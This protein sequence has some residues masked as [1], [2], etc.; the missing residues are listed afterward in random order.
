MFRGS[1]GMLLPFLVVAVLSAAIGQESLP[2]G[3]PKVAAV[4]RVF[5]QIVRAVG[6]GRPAPGIRVMPLGWQGRNRIAWFDPASRTITLEERTYDLC[7]SLGRDSLDA[8]AVLLGHELAHFYKD[9]AWGGDFGN[10]FA[11]LE[12]GKTVGRVDARPEEVVR[13][14]SQAD[15]F[16]GFYGYLAG[17]NTL[18]TASK[19][20]PL[21]YEQYTIGPNLSG[22][23]SLSDRMAIA[24]RSETRLQKFVPFFDAGNLL[25]VLRQY[26]PA[27]VLFDLL[28]REF[29]SREILNNAGVARAL[30]ALAL[31]PR[32]SVRFILPF[33]FDGMTRLRGGG[34][35][36]SAGSEDDTARRTQL[37][38]EAREK[39]EE[40][41]RR[42]PAYLP[43]RI[44]SATVSIL[45]GDGEIASPILSKLIAEVKGKR[46]PETLPTALV[47]RGISFAELG[48]RVRARADFE[49]A[50]KLGSEI[51]ARNLRVL[52]GENEASGAG[53]Q[54]T[55][56]VSLV[57]ETI[58]G[59]RAGGYPS[60]GSPE[61]VLC[62]P[63]ADCDASE[64]AGGGVRVQGRIRIKRLTSCEGVDL[65][66]DSHR[67]RALSTTRVYD[68]SSARGV[69]RGDSVPRVREMYG[70]PRYVA[71]S[72][73]GEY[74]V[75][76]NAQV[77]FLVTPEGKVEGWVI[78]DLE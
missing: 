44:N 19:L 54:T 9:H 62:L 58:G 26:E 1:T 2:A 18:G 14:E 5:N 49:E 17:Y 52:S 15:D 8:L 21:L 75:F 61:V 47:A 41:R 63:L 23:P 20:L 37:I 76:E 45:L 60:L 78:F 68:G 67:V 11:D 71:S 53:G 77:A 13:M 40:A 69:K 34:T 30:A 57:T 25:L 48:D 22:Y 33:E 65:E 28:A 6:D 35:R 7:R 42:D 12:V 3:N 74:L 10:S 43:A 16:G 66:V 64:Y 59:K 55:E 50:A 29:P 39:F 24:E 4:T 36:G 38:Q 27:M 46:T 72:A 32:D 31:Y 73:Q 51:A 70:V 56:K